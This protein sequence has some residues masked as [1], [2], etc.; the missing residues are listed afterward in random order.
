M[1]LAG[2]G[3]RQRF[4]R[5]E[6]P[7]A[8]VAKQHG[9]AEAGDDQVDVA[10]AVDVGCH[11]ALAVAARELAGAGLGEAELPGVVRPEVPEQPVR[12]TLAAVRRK[13]PRLHEVEIEPAVA[14]EVDPRHP[15]AHRLRQVQPAGR[16]RV[17]DEADSRLGRRL[18]ERE[19]AV[20][21]AG[22]ATGQNEGCRANSRSNHRPVAGGPPAHPRTPGACDRLAALA[23]CRFDGNAGS[24]LCLSELDAQ[25]QDLVGQPV[26][27]LINSV[28]ALFNPVTAL[29]NPVAA[30]FNPVA[31][32]L[33]LPLD[34][35][36]AF[37][38]LRLDPVATLFDPAAVLFDPAAA[39]LELLLDPVAAFTQL[40]LDP[41]APR[42]SFVE[43]SVYS[44]Q[45]PD[46]QPGE[47]R[48]EGHDHAPDLQEHLHF[49]L[50]RN[51]SDPGA[52]SI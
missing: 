26:D 9:G 40:N 12:R 6:C 8:P 16:A 24:P 48:K 10:V 30:L 47:G 17:V 13:R 20:F 43:A 42:G 35:V 4:R 3:S 46:K 34:P 21:A 27:P 23:R 44:T 5:G 38:Q 29:F 31:V 50:H 32:L 28:A 41:L 37:T 36:A 7:V 1:R 25:T 33:E 49:T 19:A 51:T 22:C 18:H 11:D 14:V 45:P 2:R 52:Q 39:L 15:G